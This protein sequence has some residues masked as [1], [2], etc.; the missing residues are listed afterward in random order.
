MSLHYTPVTVAA[1]VN[2]I[3]GDCSTGMDSTN[4]GTFNGLI[5]DR[6]ALGGTMFTHAHPFLLGT[7]PGVTS[8]AG[9]RWRSL[10][11]KL[12]HGDSSGGGDLADY[13]TGQ[14][15]AAVTFYTTQ[16]E[17]TDW[18]TFTTGTLRMQTGSV[19]YPLLGAKRFI[20]AAGTVATAGVSTS[21]AA[22]VGLAV[23]LGVNL[24]RADNDN[25]L[26]ELTFNPGGN[27]GVYPTTSTA[28]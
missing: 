3:V 16:G 12:R 19:A 5:I 22:V 20:T 13:S 4:G 23:S 10:A 15:P 8:T 24:L 18:Q 2:H 27:K 7:V 14:I 17:S 1:K 25:P 28:T 26:I 21:T 6:Q 9:A 11:I